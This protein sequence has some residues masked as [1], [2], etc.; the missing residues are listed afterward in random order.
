MDAMDV[1]EWMMNEEEDDELDDYYIENIE[2]TEPLSSSS[3]DLILRGSSSI[4]AASLCSDSS[5]DNASVVPSLTQDSLD[6]D[7]V[8]LVS[9][10][11]DN[12]VSTLRQRVPIA[13]T[14]TTTTVTSTST[15]AGDN[16]SINGASKKWRFATLRRRGEQKTPPRP[17]WWLI[18]ANHRLKI[19]WDVYTVL[20]SF[21]SLYATHQA[22][23]DRQYEQNVFHMFCNV[24]FFLDMLL[25]F[26]TEHRSSDG[27]VIRDGKAVWARYLTS[28]FIID[29]LSLLPWE[30]IFVKPIIEMQN[31]RGIFKKL[32]FRSRSVIRVSRKLR[33]NHFRWFG[34]VA[35]QTKHVGVKSRGL[36][37]L[38]I[39]YAPKYVLF[40]RNMR[41]VLAVRLLRQVH[42]IRRLFKN[43]YLTSS[44][45]RPVRTLQNGLKLVNKQKIANF[46][47][48]ERKRSFKMLRRQNI[49]SNSLVELSKIHEHDNEDDDDST[50]RDMHSIDSGCANVS[51]KKCH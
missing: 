30:H 49:D 19:L 21:A 36:L 20:L 1:S 9:L 40:F 39:K 24:W 8:V 35:N 16:S 46:L 28:W 32:F 44:T 33:G 18:P 47:S 22:I 50:I 37:R 29:T 12:N 13:T 26:F 6:S 15:A 14:P 25:N 45:S 10:D 7:S 34:R 51:T 23:R 2:I 17:T 43:L 27:N 4:S 31:R 5:K 41:G 38:I 48:P 42:W 11:D 3:S